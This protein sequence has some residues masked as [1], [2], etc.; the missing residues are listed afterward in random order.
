MLNH[1]SFPKQSSSSLDS[2]FTS[3]NTHDVLEMGSTPCTRR[4]TVVEKGLPR[5]THRNRQRKEN[6][7]VHNLSSKP[8]SHT[9]ISALSK[10]LSFVPTTHCN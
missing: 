7:I 6:R 4:R 2:N 1:F 9:C 3:A 10:G 8:L 5:D